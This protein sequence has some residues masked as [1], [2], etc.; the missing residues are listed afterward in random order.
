MWH[1]VWMAFL[2]TR[3]LIFFC[4]KFTLLNFCLDE[5]LSKNW[6]KE[7]STKFH[8]NCP[9]K[10]KKGQELLRNPF[11][12]LE[13]QRVLCFRRKNKAILREEKRKKH[14]L[15]SAD[16]LKILK[17]RGKQLYHKIKLFDYKTENTRRDANCFLFSFWNL[18]LLG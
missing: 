2:D 1:R 18:F 17:N 10:G 8:L 11:N 9:C 14:R 4:Y 7:S 3:V 13:K 5:K 15:L 12:S 6:K 16:L